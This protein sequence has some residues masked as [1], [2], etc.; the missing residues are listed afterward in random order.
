VTQVKLSYSPAQ[1]SDSC[2][3]GACVL[4]VP[5][6]CTI[7]KKSF[8]YNYFITID[9]VVRLLKY[10]TVLYEQDQSF[11]MSERIKIEVQRLKSRLH[12]SETCHRVIGLTPNY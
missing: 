11:G 6:V 9:G 8:K 7:L 3:R 1:G 5:V 12:S 2:L 10:V 4:V